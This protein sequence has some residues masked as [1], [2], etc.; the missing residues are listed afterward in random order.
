MASSGQ[1]G[2]TEPPPFTV[3]WEKRLQPR[4]FDFADGVNL[5]GVITD[6]ERR[7]LKDQKTGVLKPAVR[8]TVR[9]IEN[10]ATLTYAAEPVFFFGTYQIDN[11][12]RTTDVG[13]FVS[14]TCTGEDKGAGRGG[15]AMKLFDVNVSKETAPGY[16]N[17][18][19]PITEDDLPPMDAYK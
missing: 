16:A 19:T 1:T 11:A 2:R 10:I 3:S 5:V 18:G 17:D 15:N 6:V 13:H 8:Y 14:I 4:K 12:I 7:T 9:E